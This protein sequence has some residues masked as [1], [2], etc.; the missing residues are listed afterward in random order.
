MRV[1]SKLAAIA[2]LFGAMCFAQPAIA[3]RMPQDNWYYVKTIGTNGP[4]SNQVN[5][6]TGL[7]LSR[8]NQLYVV[9]TGNN[10]IQVFDQDGN[11][12]FRWGSIGSGN[13]QFNYPRAICIGTNDQVYVCDQNNNRVQVFDLQGNYKTNWPSPLP[14]GVAYSSRENAVYVADDQNKTISAY[15]GDASGALVR[16][17]GVSGTLPGQ[18]GGIMG[19]VIGPGQTTPVYIFD[20]I[21]GHNVRLQLFTPSGE[22]VRHYVFNNDY[23]GWASGPYILADGRVAVWQWYGVPYMTALLNLLLFSEDIIHLTG[24][25]FAPIQ[26]LSEDINGHT[27]TCPVGRNG[28]DI[29]QRTY[30]TIQ[31]GSVPLPLLLSTKQRP[32]TSLVDV[33]YRIV[34]GDSTSVVVAALALVDGTLSLN[35]ALVMKTFAEGTST[36]LGTNILANR[37]YHLTW[38]AAMDWATNFGN[39]KVCI[40]A[41][42]GRGLL[43]H[44]LLHIPANGTNAA[45]TI[46]RDP[47]TDADLLTCWLWLLARG[48]PA[49]TLTSGQVV[50]N[51]TVFAS[52]AATTTEG[53][54]FLFSRMGLREA[55]AAEL[56][57]VREAG[58]PGVINQ[59]TPRFQV[60]PNRWPQAVNAWGFDS[61]NWGS[62]ARWVVKP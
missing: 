18:L 62:D 39:I 35:N 56:Q 58:T 55:T 14:V 49:I 4:A 11:C 7:A 47:V 36:N 21:G 26:A 1:K 33:D 16:T 2:P 19:I 46:S 20:D 23:F 52:G 10:R 27:Y 5:N 43:D 50:S 38:N 57:Y 61:G 60:G 24:V 37:D 32:G 54:A 34:D 41:N 53:R 9:D 29:Y 45:L 40:L 12:L 30:R 42:D 31:T 22:F 17:W 25:P 6:A 28:V 59:W 44:L 8:S 3:E 51:T 48:D 13:A 15:S